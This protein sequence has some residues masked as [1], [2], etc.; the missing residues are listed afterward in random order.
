VRHLSPSKYKYKWAEKGELTVHANGEQ[1]SQLQKSNVRPIK[2]Q[3]SRAP[4]PEVNA[5]PTARKFTYE[6]KLRILA[7]A[8]QCSHGELGALC[9]REGLYSSTLSKW[10]KRRKLAMEPQ[11]AG[12]KA[13]EQNPLELR[14]AHL[15]RENARLQHRLKQAEMVIEVQK[16]I[17]EILSIPLNPAEREK[18]D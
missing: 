12:R 2:E 3:P 14:N 11:K 9:R 13:V 8:D 5:K 17:S 10:R 7:E 4:D 18:S 1:S 6:D 16:K 15:E